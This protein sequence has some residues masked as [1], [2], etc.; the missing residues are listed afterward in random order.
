MGKKL[1]YSKRKFIDLLHKNL[2]T[3]CDSPSHFLAF[4]IQKAVELE[5]GAPVFITGYTFKEGLM[6]CT[7]FNL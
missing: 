1:E 2:I 3:E 5:L 7:M 4:Y 6:M